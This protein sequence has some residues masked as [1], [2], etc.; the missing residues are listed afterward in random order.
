MRYTDK[1]NLKKPD[2]TD[3]ADVAVLNAN[4]DII[5]AAI[6]NRRRFPAEQYWQKTK[7][8]AKR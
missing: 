1:L 4:M 7:K 8:D 2:Y 5:D 6:S 3:S